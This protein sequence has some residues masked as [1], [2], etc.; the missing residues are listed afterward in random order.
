V[1]YPVICIIIYYIIYIIIAIESMEMIT[2]KPDEKRNEHKVLERKRS[3][4]GSHEKS[5]CKYG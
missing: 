3:T 5:G 2:A 1:A 4:T